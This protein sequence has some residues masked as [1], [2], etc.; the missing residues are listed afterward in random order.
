MR[1]WLEYWRIDELTSRMEELEVM[2]ADDLCDID[3]VTMG[4][5]S[6]RNFNQTLTAQL[7]FF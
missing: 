2:S 4:A 7:N 5:Q 3:P 1:T 6:S